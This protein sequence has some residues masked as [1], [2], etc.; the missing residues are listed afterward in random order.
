MLSNAEIIHQ[1]EQLK[2][3]VGDSKTRAYLDMAI[4]RQK[5]ILKQLTKARG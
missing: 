1:L 3:S 5:M 2:Q 4:V